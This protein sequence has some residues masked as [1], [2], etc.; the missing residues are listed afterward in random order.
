MANS[1][2][3]FSWTW[4]FSLNIC[5]FKV[6]YFFSFES[7]TA[8]TVRVM[9]EQRDSLFSAQRETWRCLEAQHTHLL[10]SPLSIPS[11]FSLAACLCR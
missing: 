6:S 7:D 11:P 10:S 5:V 3:V 2:T 8:W 1:H 4:L 9:R